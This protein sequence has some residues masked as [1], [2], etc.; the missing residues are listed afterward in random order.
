MSDRVSTPA[1]DAESPVE[2]SWWS[3]RAPATRAWI[4]LSVS[5]WTTLIGLVVLSWWAERHKTVPSLLQPTES[6]GL[7]SAH[8][9]TEDGDAPAGAE[10]AGQEPEAEHLSAD[11]AAVTLDDAVML[12]QHGQYQRAMRTY[13]RLA[14]QANQPLADILSF[15]MGMCA[16]ALGDFEDALAQYQRLAGDTAQPVMRDA[17]RISQARLW[18]EQGDHETAIDVLSSLMLAPS[19]GI[20]DERTESIAAHMLGDAMA[21]RAIPSQYQ[22]L[23]DDEGIVSPAI[24]TDPGMLEIIDGISESGV[25]SSVEAQ[26]L[27]VT[28]RSG[29]RLQQVIVAGQLPRLTMSAA[30]ERLGQLAGLT[31]EWSSS[32]VQ[33]ASGRSTVITVESTS[34]A[35]LLD[36]ILAP[37]DLFWSEEQ[38]K[39]AIQ[40]A[41]EVDESRQRAGWIAYAERALESAVLQ[42]PESRFVAGS[43]L[44]LGNLAFVRSALQ[45]ATGYYHL[46][47][48]KH[49][50]S[51]LGLGA[52]FNLAKVH[53]AEGAAGE[54]LDRFHHVVDAASGT[55][56]EPAAYLYAGRLLIDTEETRRSVTPLLRARALA[57]TTELKATAAT[58]L[59]MAY[60]LQGNPH[61]A[62]L[63]LMEHRS[64]LQSAARQD[65]AAFLSSL[66]R[67]QV[68]VKRSDRAR[69]SQALLAAVSNVSTE[70]FFSPSSCLLIG[71]SYEDL[72]LLELAEETYVSAC[73]AL[74]PGALNDRIRMRAAT[75]REKMG[76]IA[77]AV[78]FYRPIAEYRDSDFNGDAHRRLGYISL[79]EGDGS[80]ALAFS[81]FALESASN[82]EDRV[83]ALQ[84]MGRAYREAGDHTAAAMCF[85]GAAP[86]EGSTID[87]Q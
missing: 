84:L 23:L 32:A 81:R 42:F 64:D 19:G 65:T 1:T 36:Q 15:R 53:L 67:Y 26:Q 50:E 69:E 10:V 49:P 47:E 12:Q 20:V 73:A 14:G 35:T 61:A 3:R 68:A 37:A 82:D 27:R 51:L 40:S 77:G 41:G 48:Q 52:T 85:A 34:L 72:G 78:E 39:I 22:N 55:A 58:T 63:V 5:V 31:T 76:N 45:S 46:V 33:H 16:E 28:R 59:C 56:T 66:A 24:P 13:E 6:V 62:S 83:L 60:L 25:T 38:G 80:A 4:L 86:L 44:A 7:G 79:D 17:C 87:Q 75:V 9:H 18:M 71:Q 74:P 11:A 29:E 21:K 2:S 70:D 30:A 8:A 43:L 57:T 54:A